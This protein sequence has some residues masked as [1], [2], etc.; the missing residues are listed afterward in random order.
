MGIESGRVGTEIA[1]YRIEALCGVGGMSVVYQATDTRL[2]RKVALKFLNPDLAA[3][4][5]F[6]ERFQRESRLAASLDHPNIIPIYEA[7][8]A[9]GTLYIAMRFVVGSD[10]KKAIEERGA[11]SPAG[12][13]AVI[14]Q[15]GSALD[16]AHA[17]GLV[18]RDVK[19]ANILLVGEGDELVPHAYLA[20]F[21]LTRRQAGDGMTASGEFLGTVDYVAPEQVEGGDIQPATDVYSLGCVFFECLT[22]R[23]PY[24]RNTELATLWAHLRDDP[25]S[26]RDVVPSLPKEL[27]RVLRK[28]MAKKPDDRYRDCARFVAAA[29]EAL[30]V[31]TTTGPPKRKVS[32]LAVISVAALIAGAAFLMLRDPGTEPPPGEA[33]VPISYRN[34]VV[35]LNSPDP[36][37]LR[38]DE[39]IYAFTTQA[40]RGSAFLHFPVMQSRNLA[41][42]KQLGDAMPEL[43]AWALD[44]P[45]RDERGKKQER[46]TWAPFVM[47]LDDRYLMYFSARMAERPFFMAIGIAVAEEPEGPYEAGPTPLL[48]GKG[49]T[50]IDPF[51]LRDGDD[52]LLYWGSAGSPIT[53]QRLSADGM[54]LE[55]EPVP[56]LRPSEREYESLVEGAEVLKR[57]GYYYL[58]YSGDRCCRENAHYAL[59]VARSKSP[60]GPFQRHRENPILEGNRSFSNPGHGSII[61]DDEGLTWLLYHGMLDEDVQYNRNLM[62]DTIDW[63]DGWPVINEGRG[64]STGPRK[65]P[66]FR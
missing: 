42:W 35:D 64:P 66:I 17:L 20:D 24:P 27:D 18:H 29:K 12:A 37:V 25:P 38:A 26:I 30:D 33:P 6:R 47:E 40:V 52:L 44:E 41:G 57:N 9:D 53:A 16:A 36:A 65:A 54:Q 58:F 60:R 59:M 22:G 51:V 43:P 55:G 13:V 46:D 61:T 11:L 14:G 34:P 19:P 7:A 56:V 63:V 4:E 39:D 5:R 49:N 21:G 31:P 3:D 1:G 2:G 10:L 8:E 62:L 48:V 15:V 23:T 28:A 32:P 50:T 45:K